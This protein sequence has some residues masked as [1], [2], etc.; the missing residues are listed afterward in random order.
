[1][2]ELKLSVIR[3]T[4]GLKEECSYR[5]PLLPSSKHYSLQVAALQERSRGVLQNIFDFERCLV[6]SRISYNVINPVQYYCLFLKHVQHCL[7]D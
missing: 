5:L 3:L 2:Y 4:P 6:E 1:M 7:N